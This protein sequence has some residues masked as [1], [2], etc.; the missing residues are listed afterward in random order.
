MRCNKCNEPVG[1]FEEHDCDVNNPNKPS[2]HTLSPNDPNYWLALQ[3]DE[4]VI[5]F[6]C[7]NEL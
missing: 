7:G 3:K 6:N 1:V 2:P 4:P 5:C